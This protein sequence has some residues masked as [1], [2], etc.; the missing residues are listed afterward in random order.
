MLL[1]RELEY[2]I[3]FLALCPLKQ[4]LHQELLQKKKP[5]TKA[6][7]YSEVLERGRVLPGYQ[8]WV[9]TNNVMSGGDAFG[10]KHI[11]MKNSTYVRHSTVTACLLRDLWFLTWGTNGLYKHTFTGRHLSPG[12]GTAQAT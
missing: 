4:D 7:N 2:Y 6:R 12:W 5:K 9:C 8:E 11:V 1:P 3:F 10:D